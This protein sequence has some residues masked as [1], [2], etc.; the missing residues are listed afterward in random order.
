MCVCLLS[1]SS[2][3]AVPTQKR[4]VTINLVIV[5][6]Q[7]INTETDGLLLFMLFS[8]GQIQKC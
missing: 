1:S 5:P 4:F 8:R 3:N 2:L 6:G 7:E